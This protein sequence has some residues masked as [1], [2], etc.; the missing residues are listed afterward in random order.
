MDDPIIAY[1]DARPVRRSEVIALTWEAHT[2][3]A[4]AVSPECLPELPISKMPERVSP[5]LSIV[6]IIPLACRLIWY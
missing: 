4:R 2:E 3:K 5:Q 1:E 6:T